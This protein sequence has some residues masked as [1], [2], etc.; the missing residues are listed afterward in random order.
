MRLLEVEQLGAAPGQQHLDPVAQLGGHVQT[1]VLH[2]GDQGDAQCLATWQDG[3]LLHPADLER[4]GDQRMAGLVHGDALAVGG[5]QRRDTAGLFADA[6]GLDG[7][8]EM[9]HVHAAG[10]GARGQQR[11]M[12]DDMSNGGGRQ[13]DGVARQLRMVQ[14]VAGADLAGIEAEQRFAV[15]QARQAD[16]DGAVEATFAHQRRVEGVGEVGRAQHQ[17]AAGGIEAI[18]LGQELVDD[19][20]AFGVAGAL[21]LGALADAVD[22]VD[23]ND[24]RRLLARGAKQRLDLLD[25]DTEVHRG[26]VA[27]GHLDEAGVGFGCQCLGQLGLAGAGLAGQQDALRRAGAQRGVGGRIAQ[28]GGDV[29]ERLL[30]FVRADDVGETDAAALALHGEAAGLQ[31]EEQ[32]R[33]D[34]QQGDRR[35]RQEEPVERL[36]RVGLEHR[37]R[38]QLAIALGVLLEQQPGD[39]SGLVRYP[40]A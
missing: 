9:A 22:L 12:V 32:R 2:R 40:I 30:G 38:E 25:A 33:A 4:G 15:F 29:V 14:P 19:A 31:G 37:Q 21:L 6:A 20:V 1:L 10:A 26:K 13:A 7:I 17:H 27:A 36:L 39:V 8:D 28:V 23:E 35:V 34:Q 5:R 24:A 18:D 3:D 16:G 11:R